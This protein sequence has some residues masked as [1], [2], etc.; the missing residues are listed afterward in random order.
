MATR[1]LAATRS[2]GR[3][4]WDVGIACHDLGSLPHPGSQVAWHDVPPPQEDPDAF[5]AA[6]QRAGEYDL[7]F[8]AGDAEVLVLSERRDEVDAAVLYG[9]HDGVARAFD[10]VALA[11]AAQRAGL[12]VPRAGEA[13]SSSSRATR[14]SGRPTA[15]PSDFARK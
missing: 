6:I 7:V 8:G 12:Q 9:P 15:H 11:E 2:L 13:R 3:A 4:G 1:A 5:L 14:R 10:K